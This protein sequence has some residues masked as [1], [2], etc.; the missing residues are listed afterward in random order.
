MGYF[1]VGAGASD[2]PSGQWAAAG[3][4]GRRQQHTICPTDR[5]G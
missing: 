2:L 3:K 1:Y 5:R 4:Y